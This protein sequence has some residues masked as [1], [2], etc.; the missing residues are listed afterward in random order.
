ME[1]PSQT[2]GSFKIVTK[3]PS[4]LNEYKFNESFCPVIKEIMPPVIK[5]L[6]QP[7]TQMRH[8]FPIGVSSFNK[9]L[10]NELRYAVK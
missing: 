1:C 10:E 5:E 2:E 9:V 4:E 6:L 8:I 7:Y 3:R